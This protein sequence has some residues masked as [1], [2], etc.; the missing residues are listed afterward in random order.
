MAPTDRFVALDAELCTEP[1]I[2]HAHVVVDLGDGAHGRARIAT[3]RFLINRDGG[4]QAF[5]RVKLGLFH[6]TDKL[7]GISGKG[8]D[9]ATLPFCK[10]GIKSQAGFSRPGHPGDDHKFLLGQ[11]QVDVLE[12]MLPGALDLDAIQLDRFASLNTSL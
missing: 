7:S 2:E 9:I 8:F 12:V 11:I 4:G 3:G 1:S 10:D 6:L 5:D